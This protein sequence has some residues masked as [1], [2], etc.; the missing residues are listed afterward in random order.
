MVK[1]TCNICKAV[2]IIANP[3]RDPWQCPHYRIQEGKK[4]VVC[5]QCSKGSWI[6]NDILNCVCIA[7][8]NQKT[9]DRAIKIRDLP[10]KA[11]FPAARNYEITP[12]EFD[13]YARKLEVVEKAKRKLEEE[14]HNA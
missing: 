4:F 6:N 14:L 10:T 9:I 12:W 1:Y 2:E 11:K 3:T 5:P 7:C 13:R 8:E